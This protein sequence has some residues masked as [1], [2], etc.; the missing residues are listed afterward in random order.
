MLKKNCTYF[1]E[2]DDET[3]HILNKLLSYVVASG[4]KGLLELQN[5]LANELGDAP[6]GEIEFEVYDDLYNTLVGNYQHVM[7]RP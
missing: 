6:L 1:L 4:H 3:A 2:V 7:I 5:D